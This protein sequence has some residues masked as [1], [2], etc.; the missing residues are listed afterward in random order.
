MLHHQYTPVVQNTSI[1]TS[2]IQPPFVQDPRL[3]SPLTVAENSFGTPSR[4]PPLGSTCPLSNSHERGQE[5][6]VRSSFEKKCCLFLCVLS[7]QGWEPWRWPRQNDRSEDRGP[8]V[9]RLVEPEVCAGIHGSPHPGESRQAL[10]HGIGEKYEKLEPAHR[11]LRILF[12]SRE[13][14]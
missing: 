10:L 11:L 6:F 5:D 7:S 4:K 8:T 1:H 14:G 2:G 13:L 9:E 12:S 3:E